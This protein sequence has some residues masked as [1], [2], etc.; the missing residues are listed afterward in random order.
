MFSGCGENFPD[1]QGGRTRRGRG[2]AG[3][4]VQRKV[5][6]L[7]D[8]HGSDAGG[9]LFPGVPEGPSCAGH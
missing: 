3:R 8:E 6:L 9:A 5:K 1:G 4:E 7:G 2:S